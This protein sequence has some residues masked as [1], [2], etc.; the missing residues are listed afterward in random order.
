MSIEEKLPEPY[1]TIYQEVKD[2]RGAHVDIFRKYYGFYKFADSTHEYSDVEIVMK[3]RDFV[4][5]EY[6]TIDDCLR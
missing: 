4:K 1:E 2:W 5:R 3:A 6:R